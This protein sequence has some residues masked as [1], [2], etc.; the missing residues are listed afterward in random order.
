MFGH[1]HQPL[2]NVHIPFLSHAVQHCPWGSYVTTCIRGRGGGGEGDEEGWGKEGKRGQGK[3]GEWVV[4]INPCSTGT[5]PLPLITWSGACHTGWPK[6]SP[7][8]FCIGKYLVATQ[9]CTAI[10]H[11]TCPLQF[12]K[13][14]GPL[15]YQLW[16]N[17]IIQDFKCIAP[18]IAP[19]YPQ[20]PIFGIQEVT[21]HLIPGHLKQRLGFRLSTWGYLGSKAILVYVGRHG[22]DSGETEV[23]DWYRVA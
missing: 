4:Q 12:M 21:N 13:K 5:S 9:L 19:F 7:R 17:I 23:K 15:R 8:P 10:Q 18:S 22:G 1:L 16:V 6:Q 14:Q 20:V 2:C 3:V 11:N